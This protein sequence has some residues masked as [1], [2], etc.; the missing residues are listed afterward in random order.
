MRKL[1]HGYALRSATRRAQPIAAGRS[2]DDQD[3]TAAWAPRRHKMT[4]SWK[5]LLLALVSGGLFSIGFSSCLS[6]T[7]QRV[8]VGAIV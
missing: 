4:R 8:I 7:I 2:L 6:T 1:G 5:G 3:G